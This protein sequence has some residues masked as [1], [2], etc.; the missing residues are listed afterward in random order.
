MSRDGGVSSKSNQIGIA[1]IFNKSS[2]IKS[3]IEKWSCNEK[4]KYNHIFVIMKIIWAY[5]E[6]RNKITEFASLPNP[7]EIN[8]MIL[9]IENSCKKIVYGLEK[10][11]NSAFSSSDP[12]EV[13]KNKHIAWVDRFLRNSIA[14]D[15][16]YDD[17]F[18]K[19]SGNVDFAQ[20][21]RVSF[22]KSQIFCQKLKNLEA[23][24]RYIRE[25]KLNKNLLARKTGAPK[26]PALTALVFMA[27]PAWTGLSGRA[28]SISPRNIPAGDSDPPFVQFIQQLVTLGGGPK[29]TRKQVASAMP[30]IR[31]QL[32]E[33]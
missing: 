24:S 10:L 23:T 13:E 5:S 11:H 32:Q 28:A 22:K 30:K 29:P 6:R 31:P 8:R 27:I 17:E 12:L 20:T 21:A 25:Q 9:E 14:S 16:L 18:L 15:F 26:D 3:V 2:E 4:E 33:K 19:A 7:Q 1:E